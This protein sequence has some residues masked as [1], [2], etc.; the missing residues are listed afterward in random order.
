LLILVQGAGHEANASKPEETRMSWTNRGAAAWDQ[1][2]GRSQEAHAVVIDAVPVYRHGVMHLLGEM[3]RIGRVELV[4]A[5]AL[6]ARNTR[7]PAPA[8]LVFG[9][10]PDLAYGWHLLRLASLV[11]KPRRLLLVS[12]NMW[13]RLPPGLDGRFARTLSRSASLATI[14]RDVRALLDL[15]PASEAPPEQDAGSAAFQRPFHVLA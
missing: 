3:P 1:V 5:D 10:P 8:L 9:M 4:E 12:D 7:L 6:A 13:Q 2:L 11:L 14:E 15:P